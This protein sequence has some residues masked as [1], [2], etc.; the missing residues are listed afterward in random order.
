MNRGHILIV[1]GLLCVAFGLGVGVGSRFGRRPVMHELSPIP[2]PSVRVPATS[3]TPAASSPPDCVDIRDAGPLVG[4]SGCVS[5]QVLRIF[6]SRA[7]NTFLDFCQDYRG[8]PFTSVIFAPDKDKFGDLQ[9]LQ[10][11]KV[12][13]RGDIKN[14]R[15]RAEIIIHDPHQI[16]TAP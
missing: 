7:G 4:K 3:D 15:E 8:C 11:M 12:E 13:I 10:G 5:G 9:S 2:T 14:Y 16:S 6:T 1:T